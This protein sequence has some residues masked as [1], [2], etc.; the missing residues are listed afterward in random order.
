MELQCDKAFLPISVKNTV[1]ISI[2][3]AD[4]SKVDVNHIMGGVLHVKEDDLYKL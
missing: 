4:R 2:P 1:N 3:K